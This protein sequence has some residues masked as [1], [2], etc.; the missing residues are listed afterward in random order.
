MNI[1]EQIIA[2]KKNEV[3]EA[4]QEL[5]VKKLLQNR[6]IKRTGYS[7]KNNLLIPASTGI[8]AEFK[9]KSPSKG[10][11]NRD[12]DVQEI[13][14]GYVANGASGISIL[15]D[16][17]FFGG[18]SVDLKTARR[19]NIPIL[20]KDFIIDEYQVYETKAM[21]ADIILLIAA[22][23]TKK[24]MQQLASTARSIGLETLLEIHDEQEIDH[25]CDEINMVGI[26]NRNLKTF[27]VD[28]EQSIYLADKL[29]QG[30]IKISE[31]GID[32]VATVKLLRSEG[33]SGFLIGE[34]FMK[35][36]NPV[37]EFSKFVNEI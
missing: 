18:S 4:K 1:L 12:A 22:C 25:Y 10:F 11:I 26:N 3:A 6:N 13:T 2:H 29:P 15:T 5:P 24:E 31:S 34:Q 8:I 32:N 14:N 37:E 27:K 19:L 33:F 7:L 35:N 20:R 9:R 16:N 23:L 30:T 21:G 36:E 28:I 17:Y